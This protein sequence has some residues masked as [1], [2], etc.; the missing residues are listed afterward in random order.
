MNL[1]PLDIRKQRFRQVLRGFD[2]DE[3][4]AFLEMVGDEYESLIRKNDESKKQANDLQNRLNSYVKIDRD[5][6]DTMIMISKMRESTRIEA[7]KE[8]DIVIQNA[9]LEAEKLIGSHRRQQR[10]L[11][12]QIEQL[13]A[14][15]RSLEL[16]IRS[17]SKA[18]SRIIEIEEKTG[19][20]LNLDLEKMANA[21][22]Q[23]LLQNRMN[24][25]QDVRRLQK[26]KQA[27]I[28]RLKN[29]VEMQQKM[30]KL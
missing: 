21:D 7:R 1:T 11:Q 10:E 12:S 17:M 30:I 26:E 22:E 25:L 14:D 20:E 19:D 24:L 4:N 18:M 15:H 13:K 9:E 27:F 6:R 8:A 16:K 5:L 29:L 28:V 3:V 2:R 23:Q